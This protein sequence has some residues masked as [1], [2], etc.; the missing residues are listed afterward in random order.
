MAQPNSSP[1]SSPLALF[2]PTPQ[3][4]NKKPATVISSK[5][6]QMSLALKSVV[7]PVTASKAASVASPKPAATPAP[8]PDYV[9]KIA[10]DVSSA[11]STPNPLESLTKGIIDSASPYVTK[12]ISSASTAI[13]KP[14][15]AKGIGKST[16]GSTVINDLTVRPLANMFSGQ[17]G[18]IA[19]PK[20]GA[21]MA[22]F[23][24]F[25]GGLAQGA[26]NVPVNTA[27]FIAGL[28]G[29]F[30]GDFAQGWNKQ[31]QSGQLTPSG[32]FTPHSE[33]INATRKATDEYLKNVDVPDEL[34]AV[35]S[36]NLPFVNDVLRAHAL[37]GAVAG[38]SGSVSNSLR[39]PALNNATLDPKLVDAF[40]NNAADQIQ[41][42]LQMKE[43]EFNKL[44]GDKAPTGGV[45]NFY[46]EKIR[47]ADYSGV[48]NIAQLEEVAR[49]AVGGNFNHGGIPAEVM[50]G[51]RTWAKSAE[52]IRNFAVESSPDIIS[53]VLKNTTKQSPGFAKLPG[54]PQSEPN[55]NLKQFTGSKGAPVSEVQNFIQD[56]ASRYKGAIDEQRRGVITNQMTRELADNLGLTQE[57]LL[58]ILPGTAKNAEFLTGAADLLNTATAKVVSLANQIKQGVQTGEVTDL[59]RAQYAEALIKQ[60]ELQKVF[61]GLSAEAGRSLQSFNILK[62][63]L[64]PESESINAM[65]KAVGGKEN[66]DKFSDLMSKIN[67]NDLTAVNKFIRQMSKVSFSDKVYNYFANNIFSSPVSQT[68][69]FLSNTMRLLVEPAVRTGEAS[70]DVLLKGNNRSVHFGEVP[71][72]VMGHILSLPEAARRAL[73]VLKNGLSEAESQRI[74]G[75]RP[76]A[77]KGKIA[78]ILV[79][80][81]TRI[82]GAVDEAFKTIIGT[83]E[84]YALAY[85]EALKEAKVGT[86]AFNEAMAKYIA[87]PTAAMIKEISRKELEGT[88]QTELGKVG[89]AFYSL[90][91]AIP[92]G[93]YF[94]PVIRT[95]SNLFKQGGE[96]S[97]LGFLKAGKEVVTKNTDTLSN[98]LSKATIGSTL[99]G[100]LMQKILSGDITGSAPKDKAERSA[101]YASGKLPYAF[102][103]GDEYRSYQRIDPLATILG[104]TVD[105]VNL[106]RDNQHDAA[107]KLFQTALSQIM[108]NLQNKTYLQSVSDVLNATTDPIGSGQSWVANVGS[109]FIPYSGFI[110][111]VAQMQDPVVRNPQKIEERIQARLPLLSKQIIPKRTV[112]GDPIERPS[113]GFFG[114]SPFQT[115]KIKNDPVDTELA[116]IGY[117]VGY[118]SSVVTIP[119]VIAKQLG[120]SGGEQKIPM[121]DKEYDNFLKF[122]GSESRIW[123]FYMFQQPGYQQLSTEDK[124]KYIDLLINAVRE[125]NRTIFLATVISGQAKSENLDRALQASQK[126][127][128]NDILQELRPQ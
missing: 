46:S 2:T 123:L 47:N 126:K 37:G 109:G 15:T 103:I 100:A 84:H 125:N 93:R 85:R 70:F 20:P 27:Q 83:G 104:T 113:R 28:P 40:K 74:D 94:A 79:P 95:S 127:S 87:E 25:A 71:N 12:A 117:T 8:L 77:F 118:P 48:T 106:I 43:A 3:V 44:L 108:N 49:K 86:Q 116:N 78:K 102:K 56:V 62:K 41:A 67:P 115:S 7:K 4:S 119:D 9:T 110:N 29:E 120:L 73:Y 91:N 55:F 112:W 75:V 89:N 58:K 92:G 101:F 16:P 30:A 45:S 76:D 21:P 80:P 10:N 105:I 121:T 64:S 51:I 107:D 33:V 128:V 50:N 81:S 52:Q 38:V 53:T 114:L 36:A 31:F 14:I 17:F 65:I 122:T 19:T 35:I 54:I 22:S 61:S 90:R 26:V 111:W 60:A 23:G 13:N 68:V 18:N 57:K 124:S 24:E 63:A 59:V 96:F 42:K 32:P 99:L 1:N 34:K 39:K 5:A 98:T 66:I 88:F 72:M 97:P 82:L 69:N 11:F 6:P